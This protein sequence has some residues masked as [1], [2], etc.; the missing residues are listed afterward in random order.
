MTSENAEE[1]EHNDGTSQDAEA[2]WNTTD[3]DTGGIMAVDVESLCWPEHDDREEIGA[4]DEGDD[5]GQRKNARFL[6]QARW[7][8]GEFGTLDFPDGESDAECGSEEEGNEN[9][10]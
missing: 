2:N 7:E 10:S 4:G 9:M 5:Q 6:L 8:H 1:P 3:T